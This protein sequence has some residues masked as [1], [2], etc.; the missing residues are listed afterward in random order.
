MSSYVLILK[1]DNACFIKVGCLGKF[2]F[3]EEY[4]TYAGSGNISRIKRHLRR[5][6]RLHWHIDYLLQQAQIVEVW[7]GELE[8]CLLVEM[9]EGKLTPFIKG[10]GSS[11]TRKYSHLFIG[12]P[13]REFLVSSGYR[14]VNLII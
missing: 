8:E 10:F 1:L 6:K 3:P 11:D 12:K 2:N 14:R 4:Y 9:L 13:T 7:I 5:E